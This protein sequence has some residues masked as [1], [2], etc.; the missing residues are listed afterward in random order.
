M[1][2]RRSGYDGNGGR[3]REPGPSPDPYRELS[4]ENRE[5]HERVE[6]SLREAERIA[7]SPNRAPSRTAAP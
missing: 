6:R 7:N 4:R 1:G 5:G 3:R 2:T